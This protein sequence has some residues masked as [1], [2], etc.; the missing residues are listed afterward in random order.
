MAAL[1]I[2]VG[3]Q[4]WSA[5]RDRCPWLLSEHLAKMTLQE[6]DPGDRRALQDLLQRVYEDP[7]RRLGAED[8][9]WVGQYHLQS[10]IDEV[11]AAGRIN[12]NDLFKQK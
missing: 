10:A 1:I 2:L 4:V 6:M 3:T 9:A 12:G 11:R 7:A 8:R 5:D